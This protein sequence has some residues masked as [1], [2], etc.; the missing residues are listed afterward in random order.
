MQAA[1]VAVRARCYNPQI[2]PAIR[3]K[4]VEKVIT[5]DPAAKKPVRVMAK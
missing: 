4:P 5:F 1:A 3:T 2:K